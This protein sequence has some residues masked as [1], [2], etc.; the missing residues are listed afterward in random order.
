MRFYRAFR[1]F[2][3]DT[4]SSICFARSTNA[5]SAPDFDAPLERAMFFAVGAAIAFKHFTSLKFLVGH[6]PGFLTRI[7]QPQLVGIVD[8]REVSPDLFVS[9]D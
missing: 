1:C 4:I 3:L 8:L 2:A 7:L 9:M 5:T 6:M